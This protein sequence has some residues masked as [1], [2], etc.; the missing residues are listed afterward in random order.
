MEF[1][2]QKVVALSSSK[3]RYRALSQVSSKIA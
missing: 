1:M 3:F 2:Q